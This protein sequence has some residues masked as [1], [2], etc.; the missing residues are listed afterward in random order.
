LQA[1]Y[2]RTAEKDKQLARQ[3]LAMA[4]TNARLAKKD[5]LIGMVVAG[6]FV[7]CLALFFPDAAQPSTATFTEAANSRPAARK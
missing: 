7:V 2:S 4:E 5:F 1:E 6:V 3:Q